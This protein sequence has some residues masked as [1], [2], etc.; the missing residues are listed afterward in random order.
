MTNSNLGDLVFIA[1]PHTDLKKVSKRPALVLFDAGDR[2]F[3]LHESQP[4]NM[5]TRRIMESLNEKNQVFL[6]S[7]ISGSVN[8]QRLRSDSL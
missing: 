5:N 1:F 4:R 7:R 6:R 2:M 8:W 3:L